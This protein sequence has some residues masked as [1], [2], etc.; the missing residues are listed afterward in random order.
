VLQDVSFG[1][2]ALHEA[3]E[4]AVARAHHT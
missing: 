3:V 4:A 1:M 2:L